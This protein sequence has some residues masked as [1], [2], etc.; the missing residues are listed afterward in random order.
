MIERK[1]LVTIYCKVFSDSF[2]SEMISRKRSGL[3]IYDFLMKDAG[4]E[5]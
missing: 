4:V 2:S 1:E 3:E 5:C